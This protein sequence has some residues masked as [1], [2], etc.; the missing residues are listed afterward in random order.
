MRVHIRQEVPVSAAA[1][2]DR[3]T[4]APRLE[5]ALRA[6]GVEVAREG[7]LPPAPGTTWTAAFDWGGRRWSLR[8]VV[9][10]AERPDRIEMTGSAA[11]LA[12][13]FATLIEADGP[14]RGRLRT[15]LEVS[16]ATI[17]GRVFL[18]T[19][20]PMKPA[21]ETRLQAALARWLAGAPG[22]GPGPGA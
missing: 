12:M 13:T 18:Q 15:D 1:A 9:E 10:R 20:R 5:A 17:A 14:G 3:L 4:D 11:G 21:L 22:P 16:A 8:V 19:L 7:P 2:F 6:R